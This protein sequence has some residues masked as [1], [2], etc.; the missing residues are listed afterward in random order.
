MKQQN[1]ACGRCLY[2]CRKCTEAR[3]YH[4]HKKHKSFRHAILTSDGELRQKHEQTKYSRPQ[5]GYPY[6]TH[7]R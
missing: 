2:T 3:K 1:H 6:M 7:L 4:K 5:E